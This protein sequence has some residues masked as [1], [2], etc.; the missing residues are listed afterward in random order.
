MAWLLHIWDV[1]GEGMT[2][3]GLD[4]SKT[5]SVTRHPALWEHLYGA[6]DERKVISLL[7]WIM[8]ACCT[9][10]PSEG[11]VPTPPL[12]WQTM[13]KLQDV[14]RKL[15]MKPTI[16]AQHY[17]GPDNELFTAGMKNTALQ[18]AP[19]QWYGALVCILSPFVG[20]PLAWEVQ[21]IAELGEMEK[22][23]HQGIRTTNPKDMGE[24]SKAP[25]CSFRGLTRV[26]RKRMGQD[27][28][29]VGNPITKID[30]QP[31][32]MLVELWQKLK[33][34]RVYRIREIQDTPSTPPEEE[35][36]P[37]EVEGMCQP[38][39]PLDW[40]Y[41]QGPRRSQVTVM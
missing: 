8:A 23:R 41:S 3:T 39:R 2:L 11:D 37:L 24:G 12:H 29:A 6:I 5:A 27:L 35:A 30:K 15:G 20:H 4:M 28:V 9:T 7:S 34:T 38:P 19:G 10:W 40:G 17:R 31:N 22:I 32:A 21:T 26:T 33:S 36:L 16:Y 13:E 1:G 14:L 18:S 25:P